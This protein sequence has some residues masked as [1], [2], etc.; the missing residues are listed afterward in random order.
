MATTLTLPVSTD[1]ATVRW[2]LQHYK[3]AIM[4]LRSLYR[5]GLQP[6]EAMTELASLQPEHAS[7][8]QAAARH[9]TAGRPLHEFLQGRWPDNLVAPI[10]IAE[11]SG[12]LDDVFRGVE[13]VLSQ[14]IETRR[15]M[16][17]FIYPAAIMAGGLAIAIF[18]VTSL[19]PAMI[20][21]MRF[22]KEPAIAV[23]SKWA[24]AAMNDYGLYALGGLIAVIV[25][26]AW[27][28]SEDETFRVAA[29]AL[30]DRLPGLGR[31]TRWLWFSVWANYVAIMTSANM[32]FAEIFRITQGTLPAHLRPAVV[33]VTNHLERGQSLTLAA[34]PSAGQSDD[35]R[36]LLPL[37][38]INAFRM[39]DRAG[40]ATAQFTIASETLFEPGQE[41][42]TLSIDT[43]T[44]V[45][46][47]AA[48]LMIATPFGLYIYTVA[49]MTSSAAR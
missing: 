15:L 34:T 25:F 29:L 30:L 45:F 21:K 11:A 31:A 36:H 27:K 48:A 42:L 38:V 23:F 28:W 1:V 19:I 43:L 14:Q 3:M 10:R 16:K 24:N 18:M 6:H 41:L 26:A 32:S 47:V 35:P 12:R 49:S 17:K 33:R 20:G 37:H 39:T 7:F 40:Q 22:N 44:N 8:W 5:T 13:K 9:T 4:F 2:T 46:L